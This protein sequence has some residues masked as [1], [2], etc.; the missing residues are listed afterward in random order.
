MSMNL[1]QNLSDTKFKYKLENIIDHSNS[2]FKKD[3]VHHPYYTLHGMDHSSA[4]ISKLDKLVEGINP[5]NKLTKHE[6]FYLLA[7]VYLHDVGMLISNPEDEEKAKMSSIQKKKP[8]SKGDLI[9]DEHHIR[10]GKYIIEHELDLNLDH[11]ESECVK[12]ICEGHRVV[13]LTTENYDDRLV[14]DERVRVR[15]LAALLR[16]SDELDISYQ[17]LPNGLMDI[18]KENMPDFSRLQWLKHYYTSGVGISTRESNGNR[19]IV[20]EIQTQYPNREGGRIITE[21]ILKPIEK[22]LRIVDRILLEC[23]LNIILDPPEIQLKK[24]LDEIPKQI[25]DEFIGKKFISSMEIP[26]TKT[27]VGRNSELLKLSD[28]LDRNIIIIEGIAGIGKTYVASKFAEEIKNKY[29]IHWYGELIEVSTI[30]SVMLNLAVFLKNKGKPRLS[31]SIE[32]FGYDIEV[33]ISILKDE[34]VENNYALFFDNYHKAE[35]ELNPLMRQLLHIESSKIILITR[36]EPVFYNIVEERENLIAKVKI[37]P[38]DFKDTQEM[39]RVRGIETIE[40]NTARKIHNNL[41]GHPQYLNLFCILAKKSKP[42]TLLE[43]LPKA[44]EEAYSYL[45]NEVYNSLN[46]KEK[47]LIK[48]IA[49]YRVPEIIDAFYIVDEIE[50]IDE[51]INN[52]INRFLVN[53]IGVG[54]YNVH[55]II[56]DYCLNDVKKKKTL[57]SYHKCAAEYYLS[58]DENPEYLLEASYHYIEAGE[59]EKSAVIVIN[60]TD[61]FISKCF[62]KK[63]EEPLNDAIRTLSKHRHDPNSIEGVGLAHHCIANFYNERGDLD[64]ALKHAK[65]SSKAMMRIGRTDNFGLNILFGSIYRKKGDLDKSMEYNIKNFDIAKKNN[66]GYEKAIANANIG[67]VYSQKGDYTKA[68]ELYCNSL[69]FFKKHDETKNTAASYSNLASNYFRLKD[70]N[71]AYN[72][73]YESIK[74]YEKLSATYEIADTNAKYAEMYLKD[75]ANEGNLDSVLQCLLKNFE[76]FKQIGHLRGECKIY[77]LIGYYYKKQNDHK[78][79]IKYFKK[80]IE[81]CSDNEYKINFAEYYIISK[82]FDKAMDLLK[83]IMNNTNEISVFKCQ[84]CFLMSVSLFSMDRQE[85]AIVYINN[86]IQY[87][88]INKYVMAGLD[89]SD[90]IPI[91]DELKPLQCTLIKDLIS[92]AQNETTHPIIRFDDIDIKRDEANNYAEVFHPFAGHKKITKND[93]TLQKIIENLKLGDIVIDIDK[94]TVMEFERDTALMTLGFLYKKGFIDFVVNSK[95]NMRILLT[96][97]GKKLT[98]QLGN[99]PIK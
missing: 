28:V 31:N 97:K 26:R 44:Q 24:N 19:K 63:I 38:W 25:F 64:L 99:N 32:Y 60:H 82:E 9:R 16:F 30:S 93:E 23:G 42:E 20:I 51:I 90:I 80:S 77:S 36:K 78:S 50:D 46:K 48:I 39:C 84:A 37:D 86:T 76:I 91:V 74:L 58:K 72:Y 13:D 47:I 11:V 56:R 98:F 29:D 27:F 43:G 34:L 62:W 68:N 79:A 70:Y 85:D 94:S 40:E 92:L 7:S 54:K 69:D 45:E 95:N 14:G 52:L 67:N 6:I 55:E 65:E 73:I 75:A 35:N 5:T 4:I 61:E 81:I 2:L 33:L 49:I 41:L 1:K 15:L 3:V 18:L 57:R 59:R 17:R 87:H 21:V 12:L 88:S 10:S 22:S 96:D 53:E 66:D 83:N 71:N 89:F 8:F